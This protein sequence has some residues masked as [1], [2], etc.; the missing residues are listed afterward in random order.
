V[1]WL[2]SILLVVFLAAGAM[3]LV[4]NYYGEPEPLG[5]PNRVLVFG[6][7]GGT[8]D[9][10]LPMLE[11]GELPNIKKLY[12]TGI[13]GVLESRPPAISPVVWTTIFTGKPYTVH[14]VM[15][16]KTSQ[17]QHRKVKALW[18]ITSELG[19]KTDVFNVPSTWPPT[20]VSGVMISGFPL[21]GSTVGGGTGEVVTRESL[22]KPSTPYIYRF[23]AEAIRG[24]MDEVPVG[25][26]SEWFPVPI[27]GR[28]TWKGL[29]RMMRLE[30]DKFYLSPCYRTDDGLEITYPADLRR[31]VG[32]RLG[33]AYIPEGPGWSK[34]AEP[35]T[36]KYL[37]GHL[38]QVS[39]IQTKAVTLFADT[40]WDLLIYVDTF[41]DRISHP[42]W[43]YSHPDDYDG[44]DR[45]KAALYSGAVRN[46]YIEADR[47]LGEV[48]AA[49][50]GRFYTVLASDHGFHSNRNRKQAIGTHAFNGIY[51]VSGPGV[52]STDGDHAYIEDMTPTILT[53]M[54]LPP[55]KDMQGKT[56]AQVQALLDKP[57]K[58]VATYEGA[59]K[60]GS[61]AP[62]DAST[63]EQLRALGYVDGPAPTKSDAK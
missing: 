14:G 8:W 30:Q 20:P 2:I 24:H 37:Y 41:V 28:P 27:R 59:A 50:K 1:R 58:M 47:Q 60:T 34:W 12:D 53:L 62:V 56:I 40:D 29:M 35:D 61:N 4:R 18:D 39:R 26:W 15:N 51:L 16:W 13:H 5:R 17:S 48:L 54:G 23:N 7:D 33:D 57:L 10:M 25:D 6:I 19:R 36:P 44:L 45:D 3:A 11:K 32:D 43:A 52:E 42:Y 46:A 55:A 9:V 38:L 21:S 31:R 63:W 22:A 49:A